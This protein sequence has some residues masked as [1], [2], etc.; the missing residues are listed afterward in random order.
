MLDA[1]MPAIRVRGFCPKEKTMEDEKKKLKDPINPCFCTILLGALVI[2]FAWWKVSWGA[3]ALT[4]LGVATIA[5]GL[6]NQCCC[7]SMTCKPKA[8]DPKKTN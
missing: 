1:R 5:K 3:F 4:L 2:L 6:I 8:E 7:Q